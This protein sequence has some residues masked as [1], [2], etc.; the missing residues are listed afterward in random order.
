MLLNIIVLLSILSIISFE[1]KTDCDYYD[2]SQNCTFYMTPFEDTYTK[3]FLPSISL[4]KRKLHD[5]KNVCNSVDP[6]DIDRTNKLIHDYVTK[7]EILT[8][9]RILGFIYKPGMKIT[10]V[11]NINSITVPSEITTTK[12]ILITTP[13]PKLDLKRKFNK[14]VKKLWKKINDNY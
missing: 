4:R 2:L 3:F 10:L 14:K 7:D 11:D 1:Y 8:F 5:F 6:R 12:N 13:N 9:V